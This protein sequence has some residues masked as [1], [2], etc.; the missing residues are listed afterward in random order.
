MDLKEKGTPGIKVQAKDNI[1]VL[2]WKQKPECH[3]Q[4]EKKS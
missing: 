1:A 4:K 3:N 2:K